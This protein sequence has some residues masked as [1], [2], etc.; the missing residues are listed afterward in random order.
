VE[1]R[2]LEDLDESPHRAVVTLETGGDEDVGQ[3]VA[4]RQRRQ[5]QN[6]A[7]N[8]QFPFRIALSVPFLQQNVSCIW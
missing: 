1:A 7:V 5:L 4:M 8:F 2:S 3:A 6:I